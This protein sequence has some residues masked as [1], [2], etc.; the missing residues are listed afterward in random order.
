MGVG[1]ATGATNEVV[2]VDLFIRENAKTHHTSQY[3][4]LDNAREAPLV[5]RR[6]DSIY[7][8]V[9]LMR[10]YA[11][12]Q[13]KMRLEFMFGEYFQLICNHAHMY[14]YDFICAFNSIANNILIII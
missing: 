10:P 6:G 14:D 3:E 5:I 7:F 8:A 13:D 1:Q 9:H 11:P 2:H 12:A 4:I